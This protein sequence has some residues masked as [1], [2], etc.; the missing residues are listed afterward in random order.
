MVTRIFCGSLRLSQEGVAFHMGSRKKIMALKSLS[1]VLNSLYYVRVPCRIPVNKNFFFPFLVAYQPTHSYSTHTKFRLFYFK[2]IFFYYFISNVQTCTSA[3]AVYY[4]RRVH[5]A[6]VEA[7][8]D[9]Y[10]VSCIPCVISN[11][12]IATYQRLMLQRVTSGP[13]LRI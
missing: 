13:F 8:R 12:V 7:S 3:S 9:L 4:G 11:Y 10:F 1:G 2:G 6:I 5:T